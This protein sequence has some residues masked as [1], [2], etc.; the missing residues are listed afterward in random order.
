MNPFKIIFKIV[1]KLITYVWLTVLFLT[2]VLPILAGGLL[3]AQCEKSDR[4]R[5]YI[6]VSGLG[7]TVIACGLFVYFLFTWV[8]S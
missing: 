5:R 4:R 1:L 2:T 3:L 7:A 8:L 6:V